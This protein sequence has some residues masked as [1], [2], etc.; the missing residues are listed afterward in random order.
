ML[1]AVP[2]CRARPAAW[3]AGTGYGMGYRGANAEVWD[4]R[5][6]AAAQTAHDAELQVRMHGDDVRL[7][8]ALLPCTNLGVASWKELMH[9]PSCL[10][11]QA[12][13]R[14][15]WPFAWQICW[16]R[17]VPAAA[18]QPSNV[19]APVRQAAMLALLP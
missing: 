17:Q 2:R 8:A 13:M 19:L 12:I 10:L 6:A 15:V 16:Q 14:R 18:Q 4:S 3:A 9:L 7:R 11:M 1:T 5:A